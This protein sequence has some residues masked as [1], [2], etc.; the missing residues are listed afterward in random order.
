MKEDS[1]RGV[2]TRAEEEDEEK[3]EKEKDDDDAKEKEEEGGAVVGRPVTAIAA[4]SRSGRRGNSSRGIE[5][6]AERKEGKV[7][8]EEEK[9]AGENE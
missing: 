6:R 3:K 7:E 5:T 2:E 9:E 1:P 8:N 4:L